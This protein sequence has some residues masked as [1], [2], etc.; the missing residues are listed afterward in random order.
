MHD[1]NGRGGRKYHDVDSQLCFASRR[2]LHRVLV[3]VRNALNSRVNRAFVSSRRQLRR[4][5]IRVRNDL[6]SRV[7]LA[8]VSFANA[9]RCRIPIEYRISALSQLSLWVQ[10]VCRLKGPIH[11]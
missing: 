2:Q 7:N 1:H 8:F 6:N 3:R 10:S 5:L 4:V 9:H 11:P